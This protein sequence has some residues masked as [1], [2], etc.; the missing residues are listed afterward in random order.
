VVY[1]T[2]LTMQAPGVS[3]IEPGLL[4]AF[5]FWELC[6]CVVSYDW[7]GLTANR[8]GPRDVAIAH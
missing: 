6:L 2:A 5:V 7:F 1:H 4:S 8:N 3:L